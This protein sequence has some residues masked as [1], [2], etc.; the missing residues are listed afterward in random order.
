MTKLTVNLINPIITQSSFLIESKALS[1]IEVIIPTAVRAMD[2]VTL[3]CKYDLEGEPLYTVKWYQGMDE[4]F[5]YIPKE[6]PNMLTFPTSQGLDV[7]VSC[8]HHVTEN[9]L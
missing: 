1:I 7:D 5:R 3:H 4:F 2:T 6:H 9:I 8:Y